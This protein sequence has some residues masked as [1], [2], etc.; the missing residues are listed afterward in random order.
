[1]DQ[2][3]QAGV[4]GGGGRPTP[5]RPP[6][7]LRACILYIKEIVF[8]ELR[9]LEAAVSAEVTYYKYIESSDIVVLIGHLKLPWKCNHKQITTINNDLDSIFHSMWKVK[10][11]N[12][13]LDDG[14][15]N[16]L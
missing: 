16:F 4:R 15:H 8:A 12:Y 11:T 2:A 9:V 1:M 6:P 10:C 5:P 14:M 7:W 3:D 13:Q